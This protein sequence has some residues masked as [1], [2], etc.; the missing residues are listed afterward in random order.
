MVLPFFRFQKLFNFLVPRAGLEPARSYPKDFKSFASTDSATSACLEAAPGF[1]PGMRVLQT[2]ALPLGY[3]A[4]EYVKVAYEVIC[5][6]QWLFLQPQE[7]LV[8]Q[9]LAQ[10]QLALLLQ[11]EL[12][13]LVWLQLLELPFQLLKL[14]RLW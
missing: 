5:R 3:A 6:L 4:R 9:E 13:L 10:L 2:L 14:Q 1:E 11:Q 8:L 7:L 12:L